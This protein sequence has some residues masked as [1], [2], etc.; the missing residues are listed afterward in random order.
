M[1]H[2]IERHAIQHRK[3]FWKALRRRARNAIKRTI[4]PAPH[5][6]VSQIRPVFVVG[7]GH[8]GTS[9]FASR[10]GKHPQFHLIP[11][12]TGIFSPNRAPRTSH[13]TLTE[14][15]SQTEAMGLDGFVE[16]TP[17][18]V[19]CTSQIWG[20]LPEAK[21]VGMCRNPL[22]NIASL[23]NR[24]GDLQYSIDRWIIDNEALLQASSDRRL[25]LVKY[26]DF[27]SA[28]DINAR[29][30]C[31]FLGI[32]FSPEMLASGKTAYDQIEQVKNNMKL[33]QLQVSE[34]I[35]AKLGTWKSILNPDQS[36]Q[37]WRATHALAQKLGYVDPLS[38]K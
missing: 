20:L 32:P 21:I 23:L 9:L 27:T 7:C 26:E 3:P 35:V 11:H 38:K 30:V 6:I 13:A 17:K 8:S 36:D 4:L 37:A 2:L 31:E 34:P 10:L 12:E 15:I 18:H 5:P 14:W 24:F 25:L 19:H 22:D 1:I 29:K 33:R 16:K 28:P